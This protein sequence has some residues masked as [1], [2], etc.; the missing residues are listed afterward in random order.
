IRQM[1]ADQLFTMLCINGVVADI[2]EEDETSLEEIERLLSETEWMQDTDTV[3]ESRGR[4]A[5]LVR[6]VL[7]DK[8]VPR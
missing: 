5:V 1:A 2:D 7:R 6:Q 4:L 8:S 3:K